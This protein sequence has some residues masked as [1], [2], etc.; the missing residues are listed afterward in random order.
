MFLHFVDGG[1][2]DVGQLRQLL[3]LNDLYF[4]S[5]LTFSLSDPPTLRNF[6]PRCCTVAAQ[7]PRIMSGAF[8]YALRFPCKL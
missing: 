4:L 3:Y 7:R 5:L 2:A 8:F 1:V 6:L